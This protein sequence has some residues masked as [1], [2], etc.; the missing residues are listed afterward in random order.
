MAYVPL[1]LR[2]PDDR[3][4]GLI[5]RVIEPYLTEAHYLLAA[6]RPGEGPSNHFPYACALMLLGTIA[7]TSALD[8]FE[9]T[10]KKRTGDKTEFV[11]CLRDHFPWNCVSIDDDKFRPQAELVQAT[12]VTLY[13]VF[14]CPLFHSGGLVDSMAT[15]PV[16]VKAHPGNKDIE[17]AEQR[18][19]ELARQTDLKGQCLMRMEF[20]RSTLYVDCLYWCVRRMVEQYSLDETHT[21]RLLKHVNADTVSRFQA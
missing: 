13:E 20:K 5:Q 21:R 1:T 15:T 11:N 18:V 12:C 10:G 19:A 4:N 2:S 16:I 14:R 9:R 6:T 8:N 3:V 17:V 7:A